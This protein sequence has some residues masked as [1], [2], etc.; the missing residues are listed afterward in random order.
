MIGKLFFQIRPAALF[1]PTR[2]RQAMSIIE[3][4]TASLSGLGVVCGFAGPDDG[5]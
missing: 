5:A 3:R 2:Q 1:P 4:V